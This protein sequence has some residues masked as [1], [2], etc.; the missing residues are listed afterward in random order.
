MCT[1]CDH[2]DGTAACRG[3]RPMHGANR[4]ASMMTR[5]TPCSTSAWLPANTTHAVG[6]ATRPSSQASCTAP[7][8]KPPHRPPRSSVQGCGETESHAAGG[9]PASAPAALALNLPCCGVCCGWHCCCCRVCERGVPCS[10]LFP[11]GCKSCEAV[12]EARTAGASA[13]EDACKLLDLSKAGRPDMNGTAQDKHKARHIVSSQSNLSC[14]YNV[15]KCSCTGCLQIPG[16][17]AYRH[18]H[19]GV[20][21]NHI[22]QLPTHLPYMTYARQS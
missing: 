20:G 10:G 2:Q 19:V 4:Y 17:P 7:V 15:R 3:R 21:G 18:K 13:R 1:C 9:V 11:A 6:T 8:P 14:Q 12:L 22:T 16:C 5:Y